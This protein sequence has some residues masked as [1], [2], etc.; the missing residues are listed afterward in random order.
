[1]Q[2]AAAWYHALMGRGQ[3]GAKAAKTPQWQGP[4]RAQAPPARLHERLQVTGIVGN[5][6]YVRVCRKTEASERTCN[7]GLDN[8]CDGNTDGM[9]TSCQGVAVSR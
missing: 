5:E 3:A 2:A 1:M 7:D 9:D 8:D 4:G 6:A